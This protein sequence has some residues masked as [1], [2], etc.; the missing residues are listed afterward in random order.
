MSERQITHLAV[1]DQGRVA[2]LLS[3]ADLMAA[4]IAYLERIF[5][6]TEMDQ[7]LLFRRGTY[8]C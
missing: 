1:L 2:G 5:R 7:K 3:K 6:E 4:Q 8:S